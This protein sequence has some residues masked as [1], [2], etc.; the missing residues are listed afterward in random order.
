MSR[1]IR[2]FLVFFNW[3]AATCTDAPASVYPVATGYS[4]HPAPVH[5]VLLV[6]SWTSSQQQL[7]ICSCPHRFIRL[8]WCIYLT[9]VVRTIWTHWVLQNSSNSVFLSVLSSCFAL[10]GLFTSFLGSDEINLTNTLVPMIA[11]SLDHQNHSKWP[12]WGHV[13][14]NLLLFGDWWQHNQ[15]KHKF[16]EIDKFNHLHLLGCLP[17]SNVSL[18]LPLKPWSPPLFLHLSC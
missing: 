17:P 13:H 11:L 1:I 14:Y 2:C 15:S 12:K 3:D 18:G 7:I 9:W 16:A 5:P 10:L 6:W 4:G 8:L